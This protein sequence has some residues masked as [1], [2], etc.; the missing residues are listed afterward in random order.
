MT[1]VTG[2]KTDT[3]PQIGEIPHQDAECSWLFLCHICGSMLNSIGDLR[4]Q[5]SILFTLLCVLCPFLDVQSSNLQRI[6][7][8]SASSSSEATPRYMAFRQGLREL[9][10]VEG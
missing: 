9:G 5:I 7:Y 3:T 4:A 8:L 2:R 1:E 10:Y 6:G